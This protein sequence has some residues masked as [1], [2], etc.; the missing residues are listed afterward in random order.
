MKKGRH[1]LLLTLFIVLASLLINSETG[2]ARTAEVPN[3]WLV[4]YKEP[5]RS[6]A[7]REQPE[8]ESVEKIAPQVELLTFPEEMSPADIEQELKKDPLIEYVEPNMERRL[9]MAVNDPHYSKQ[10]WIPHVKAGILWDQALKQK[11]DIVVAVIDTGVDLTHEDLKSRIAPG[12]YNFYSNTTNVTDEK[13]HGTMVAGVIAAQLNNRKGIAGAAGPYQVSILPLKIFN[14]DSAS[15]S[16]LI[17]AIDYA[18]SQDVDIINLSLGGNQFSRLENEAI[19]RAVDAGITVIAAAGN[20]A[21]VGNP[22]MYPAAYDHVISVGAINSSNVK[23]NF[24]TYNQQVDLV[25]PG[26]QILST[27]PNQTYRYMDGTSFAAPIVSGTVAM[28]KGLYPDLST[29]EIEQLLR[30]SATDLGMPG[31][32]TYYGMGALDISKLYAQLEEYEK[33]V[34]QFGYDFPAMQVY[35]SKVFTVTFNQTLAADQDFSRSVTISRRADGTEPITS[36]A[37]VVNPANPKQLLI[38]PATKWEPGAHYLTITTDV[39]NQNGQ[40]LKKEVHMKFD[41]GS[42]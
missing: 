15:L 22:V 26:Q 10:W 14:Q 7:A 5:T 3:E 20:D 27:F 21:L 12:G 37:A 34:I 36:F 41:V 30:R 11:Q 25:A 4:K 2:F 39:R 8:T 24:S 23:A 17:R 40:P 6:L 18:V 32:D 28:M 35:D 33:S 31:F 29:H 1:L 19:Q 38:T 13:G 9:M 16:D 42:Y